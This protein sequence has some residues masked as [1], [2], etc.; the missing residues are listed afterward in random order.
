MCP[1][2]AH[3]C[4]IGVVRAGPGPPVQRETGAKANII[5]GPL[6]RAC[7]L[8]LFRPKVPDQPRGPPMLPGASRIHL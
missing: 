5:F 8:V 7:A 6:T 2:G 1:F 3:V 4:A